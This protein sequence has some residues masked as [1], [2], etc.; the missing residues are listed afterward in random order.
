MG[1]LKTE[2]PLIAILLDGALGTWG[3]HSA[4]FN[5]GSVGMDPLKTERLDRPVHDERPEV[6][7]SEPL[8][9]GEVASG[10][11]D[12]PQADRSA[13]RLKGTK[14]ARGFEAEDA[15]G[16]GWGLGFGF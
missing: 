13:D 15:E 5:G 14:G 10:E 11:P 4:F 12:H 1:F 9:A 3:L 6:A 16:F 7:I 2:L 8:L